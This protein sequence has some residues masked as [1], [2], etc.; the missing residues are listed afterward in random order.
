MVW[1]LVYRIFNMCTDVDMQLHMRA[2]R[3][4]K[5]RLRWKLTRGGKS[6]RPQGTQS[7]S[8]LCLAFWSEALPAELS[9][10]QNGTGIASVMQTHT[11]TNWGVEKNEWFTWE[12]TGSVCTSASRPERVPESHS[13]HLMAYTA[14][15][16]PTRRKSKEPPN[17]GHLLNSDVIEKTGMCEAQLQLSDG[18]NHV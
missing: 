10:P 4:P 1:L 5:A 8:V 16:G 14:A 17:R 18:P 9:C 2:V 3:T 7:M 12:P 15:S 13:K 11:E 6:L